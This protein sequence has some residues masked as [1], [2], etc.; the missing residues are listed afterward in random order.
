MDI[1]RKLE[2]VLNKKQKKRVVVLLFMII[3]GALLE[4]LSVSMILPIV[5]AVVEPNAFETNELIIAVSGIFHHWMIL[6]S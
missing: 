1:I 3:I 2:A 5:Q 6:S 4:T